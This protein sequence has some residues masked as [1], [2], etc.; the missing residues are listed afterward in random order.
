MRDFKSHE[1]SQSLEPAI[2]RRRLQK[3]GQIRFPSLGMARAILLPPTAY[4]GGDP[5]RS[6][7][8]ATFNHLGKEFRI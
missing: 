7:T 4:A 8:L 5:C 3:R 1:I 2:A 6:R